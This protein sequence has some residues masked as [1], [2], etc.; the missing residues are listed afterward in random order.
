MHRIEILDGAHEERFLIYFRIVAHHTARER[1]AKDASLGS[2]SSVLSDP[3]GTGKQFLAAIIRNGV[4]KEVAQG[5]I[6]GFSRC[7]HCL[8]SVLS[9]PSAE[10]PHGIGIG[11]REQDRRAGPSQYPRDRVVQPRHV[12][13]EGDSNLY[14]ECAVVEGLL[15]CLTVRVHML[16]LPSLGLALMR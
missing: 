7:K 5:Q 3:Q 8:G 9:T 16:T 11:N 13:Q 1:P 12:G 14:R 15:D 2:E 10:L 6:G 4:V